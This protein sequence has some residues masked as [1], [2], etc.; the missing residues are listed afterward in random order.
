MF[1]NVLILALSCFALHAF[2]SAPKATTGNAGYYRF[3]VGDI[4]VNT[5]NDGTFML[6]I[7]K[8]L[9]HIK[10]DELKS[11]LAKNY[12]GE[13]VETSDDAF[14]INTGT[15][16]VLIDTGAG[17]GMGPTAGHLV[18]SLKAAGYRPEQVDAILITHMHGDHT[19][20]LTTNGK[21]NF[22]NA[23]L[24]IDKADIDYWTNPKNAEGK[25]DM[26]KKTFEAA[27]PAIA[28][29]QKAGKLHPITA[30][31]EITPGVR[32]E[33]AHG[34]TPGHTVYV[35][36]NGGQKLMLLGDTVHVA[37]V[38]F[39]RPSADMQFDADIAVAEKF[40][41]G[42]FAD[43]AKNGYMIGAAHLPF[44]GVGHLRARPEKKGYAFVPL[45]Y[46]H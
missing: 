2:A 38:Q 5:I 39:E 18:E 40:R 8:M 42:V 4:E 26:M 3:H 11:A 20:G 34:H 43:A 44:P 28:P 12:L 23:T 25:P 21:A 31:M 37:A 41:T 19:G 6:P 1:K 14:L 7:D 30:N 27:G 32:T 13:Q 10:P 29:Y 17:N 16:L 9:T 35:I 15:K 33:A 45:N 22:P 36:E 46:T 24:Y